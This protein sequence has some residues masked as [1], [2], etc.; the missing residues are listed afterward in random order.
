MTDEIK[1]LN[2]LIS[3]ALDML[4]L[5]DEHLIVNRP[6]TNFGQDEIHHVGERAI[7]FRFAHYL[8]N[9]V[10]Q[11]DIFSKYDLDCEYNR[12]GV[13]NKKLPSFPNGTYPDVILHKRGS[14]DYNLLVME[15]KTYWNKN[16][17]DDCRKICEFT[18]LSGKYAFHYGMTVL[19]AKSRGKVVCEGYINGMKEQEKMERL[20]N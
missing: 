7:V 16:Q 4:Y 3:K 18:S 10:E 11:D 8:Q 19:I 17:V 20:E 13:S 12:N 14:N 5:K 6:L 9:L 2:V 15:F 1:K